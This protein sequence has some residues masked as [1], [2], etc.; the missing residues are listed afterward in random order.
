MALNVIGEPK[1]GQ[2]REDGTVEGA[3]GGTEMMRNRLFSTIDPGLL[4]KVQVIS[5]RVRKM[6]PNKP[7]IL[8]L[9]DT[10]NDPESQV[11]QNTEFVKRIAAFVF[12][13][14]T[15]MN[16]YMMAFNLPH[17]KCHVI[18]NAIEPIHAS[19]KSFDGPI[20][21]IYH[22]TPHR[23]LSLLVAAFEAVCER[24]DITL[25]VYSSFEAYGRKEMDAPFEELFER[26]RKHPRITYHGYK[27][28]EEV[29]HALSGAHVF[30]YPCIW[31]ETSCISAIEAMSAKCMILASDYWALSETVGE[32]GIL[33]RYHED[34]N[35]HANRFAG[36]L[37][38]LCN[39]MRENQDLIN[40]R[41]DDQKRYA[42]FVYSWKNKAP[43]WKALL[44]S[45]VR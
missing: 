44:E 8:W 43:Q 6:D 35:I 40:A 16:S 14:Y 22:T 33:Y 3:M 1:V 45:L 37:L 13:S 11:L 38:N 36:L 7:V 15:Q 39:Y 41:T 27:S 32:Y 19:K 10:W 24:A 25:D 29:R 12:V 4:D 23:G 2:V 26:C 31:P 34:P 5:S 42:D 28:N 9:H 30:T 17:S 20:R 21:C 18:R